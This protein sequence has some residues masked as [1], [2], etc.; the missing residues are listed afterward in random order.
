MLPAFSSYGI[1]LEYMIVDRESL[2]VLPIA[3]EVLHKLSGKYVSEVE[4][5]RLAWSNE[6]VL[7]LLEL[8]N[9]EPEPNI[10]SLAVLFQKEIQH[11]NNELELMGARLMPSAMHPWMNPRIETRLWPHDHAEIYRAYDHIFDCKRHGWA[12]LQSMHLNMPFADDAEFARLHA[13]IRLLLPIL[14]ALAASS[15][16][17]EGYQASFLDCRMQNYLTHQIK[18]PSTMGKVIPD[19]ITTRAAYEKQ[20]LAPMYQEITALDPKGILQHEWFNVRGAAAR[21][22]RNAIEIRVI[23][24]QECPYVDLAIA[25]VVRDVVHALYNQH[26]APFANQQ[27]IST[28][29]LAKI[30]NDCIRDAEQARI[31]DQEYLRL[32]GCSAQHCEA[33][34]LWQHLIASV[35]SERSVQPWQQALTVILEQGTLARRILRAVDQDFSLARL[36]TVYRELCDCLHAGRLFVGIS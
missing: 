36:K 8:K 21:F 31:T 12:N 27:A 26:T 6:L 11:I 22:V 5:G 33:R 9:A 1:E 14:P 29:S 3:D 24:I 4:C 23:D 2:S 25:A 7:H 32:M 30:L 18:I 35:L 13:A 20:I 15:P 28:D 10:E 16:I 17:V 34:E 19:T